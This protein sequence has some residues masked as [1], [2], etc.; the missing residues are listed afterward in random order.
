MQTLT[1]H[2]SEDIYRHLKQVAKETNQSLEALAAQ[3]IQGNLPPLI[4]GLPTDWHNDL[5]ELQSLDDQALWKIANEV[6]PKT[7]WE[8]HQELLAQNQ[9]AE[10][11]ADEAAKLAYLR[12]ITDRFVLRRS[13]AL[14]ILKWRGYTIAQSM[15]NI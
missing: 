8:Q 11:T 15:P 4:E 1:L 3:A 12:Q 6:I 7:Q 5:V 14:A 2:L 9:E 13:Y 10:L